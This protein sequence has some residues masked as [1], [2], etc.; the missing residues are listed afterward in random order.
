MLL[1]IRWGE[2]FGDSCLRARNFEYAKTIVLQLRP[3]TERKHG[4]PASR[5]DADGCVPAEACS[6]CGVKARRRPPGLRM[7]PYGGGLSMTTGK[8]DEGEQPARHRL[9]MRTPTQKLTTPVYQHRVPYSGTLRDAPYLRPTWPDS[10]LDVVTG[11]PGVWR[12]LPT[13]SATAVVS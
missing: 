11:T 8:A 4:W 5:R 13:A 3:D 10:R 12:F 1:E 9:R 6:S 7:K 2:I